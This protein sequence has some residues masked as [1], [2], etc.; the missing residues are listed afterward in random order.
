VQKREAVGLGLAFSGFS[1]PG[2]ADLRIFW[3][4]TANGAHRGRIWGSWA[5]VAGYERGWTPERGYAVL[6]AAISG[7][8]PM[9][10]MTRLRL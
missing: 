10:F 5:V 3:V 9:M 1:R 4:S 7:A 2:G 8:M 6:I